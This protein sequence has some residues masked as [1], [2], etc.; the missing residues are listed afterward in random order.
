MKRVGEIRGA[1]DGPSEF[2][3]RTISALEQSGR[4]ESWAGVV[5]MTEK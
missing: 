3:L 4:P 1:T 2:Y 5:E